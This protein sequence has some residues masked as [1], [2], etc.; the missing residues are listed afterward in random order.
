MAKRYIDEALPKL[1]EEEPNQRREIQQITQTDRENEYYRKAISKG[2]AEKTVNDY[3]WL[4]CGG[5][6]VSLAYFLNKFFCPKGVEV[7]PFKKLEKLWGVK[8][9]D[10][11]SYQLA[12]TKKPQRWRGYIDTLFEK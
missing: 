7:I 5:A 10:S 6:K 2:M 1:D 11:T 12:N 4:Y 9:L 3:K 8:R